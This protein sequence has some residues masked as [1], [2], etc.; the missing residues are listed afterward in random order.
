MVEEEIAD[1]ENPAPSL[2]LL[3]GRSFAFPGGMC[4]RLSE[5]A[6]IC[7]NRADGVPWRWR[8][9]RTRATP[10]D[11]RIVV[12]RALCGAL[13]RAALAC[14]QPESALLSRPSRGPPRSDPLVTKGR[15]VEGT[16]GGFRRPARRAN[17]PV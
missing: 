7:I 5:K 1:E 8:S 9:W 3:W 13:P 12:L 10:R 17:L 11:L 2:L 16:V 6:S 15:T 4:R 14:G